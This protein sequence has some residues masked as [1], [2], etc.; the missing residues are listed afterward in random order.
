MLQGHF[1]RDWSHL[2]HSSLGRVNLSEKKDAREQKRSNKE[3][4]GFPYL[5]QIVS[6]RRAPEADE[7]PRRE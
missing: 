4:E 6:A 5:P 2:Y 7:E 3:V 1:F